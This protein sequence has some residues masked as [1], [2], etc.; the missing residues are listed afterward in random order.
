M[1]SL[2]YVVSNIKHVTWFDAI[3]VTAFV[4]SFHALLFG[5]HLLFPT[6]ITWSGSWLS[7]IISY[8]IIIFLLLM[9]YADI[10]GD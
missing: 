9:V 2:Y 10:K 8:P 5:L 1:K 3:A 7:F 6:V 4:S